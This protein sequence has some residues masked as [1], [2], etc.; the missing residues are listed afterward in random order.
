MT[1]PIL[2]RRI[3]TGIY[4]LITTVFVATVAYAAT[5]GAFADQINGNETLEA[6]NCD[7][8]LRNMQSLLVE[9]A[10]QSLTPSQPD[11][12]TVWNNHSSAW[13]KRLGQLRAACTN[14]TDIRH[15]KALGHLHQAYA[16]SVLGFDARARRA[17]STLESTNEKQKD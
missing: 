12:L 9:H 10:H 14:K 2:F 6:E 13:L 11:R 17:I 1:A 4:L 5:T 8:E 15:L 16:N 7:G 3:F